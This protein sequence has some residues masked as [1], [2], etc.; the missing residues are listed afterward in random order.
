MKVLTGSTGVHFEWWQQAKGEKL[1]IVGLHFETS[2]KKLNQR[3]CEYF[4]KQRSKLERAVGEKLVFDP[5]WRGEW[6]SVNIC[7]PFPEW[8]D[9][10]ARWAAEKMAAFITATQPMIDSFQK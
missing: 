1:L 2:S 5:D 6:A 7:K 10:V 4:R 3:W 9:K 8:S